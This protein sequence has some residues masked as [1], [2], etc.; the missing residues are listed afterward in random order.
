MFAL[1]PCLLSI[2]SLVFFVPDG[3]RLLVSDVVPRRVGTCD[4]S[5]LGAGFGR[6]GS[7][8]GSSG[9]LPPVEFY[10]FPNHFYSL[11][12]IFRDSI[13]IPARFL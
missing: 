12:A 4:Y 1:V 7:G 3:L 9:R 2:S 6:S 11:L 10:M 8:V 5:I 13:L